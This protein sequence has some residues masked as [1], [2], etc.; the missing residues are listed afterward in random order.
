[1]HTGGGE[2]L[3]PSVYANQ[4]ETECLCVLVCVH[5]VHVCTPA[6][7][8]CCCVCGSAR[9]CRLWCT[10]RVCV[11]HPSFCPSDRL[12]LTKHF[13]ISAKSNI[14]PLFL[15]KNQ[16]N[17]IKYAHKTYR[18][19]PLLSALCIFSTSPLH[20]RW[21]NLLLQMLKQQGAEK[22]QLQ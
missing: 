18:N 21:K 15:C 8:H 19:T 17:Y 3:N 22:Q 16:E 2:R 9:L 6:H 11:H 1:M 13:H 12:G 10:V 14:N 7:L 5:I 4:R 20:M